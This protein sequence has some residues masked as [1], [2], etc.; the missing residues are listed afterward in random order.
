MEY[1]IK[2]Y[3]ELII[4]EELSHVWSFTSLESPTKADSVQKIA[5][6]LKLCL[7]TS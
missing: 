7:L 2:N 5:L 1:L 6:D 4:K 3:A